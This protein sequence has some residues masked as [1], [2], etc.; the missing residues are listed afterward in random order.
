MCAFSRSIYSQRSVTLMGF[1]QHSF[2][3]NLKVYYISREFPCGLAIKDCVL[4]PL[5]FGFDLPKGNF[6]MPWTWPKI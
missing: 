6:C 3:E 5:C 2:L 4:S 1:K